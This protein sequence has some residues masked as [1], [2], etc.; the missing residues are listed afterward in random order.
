VALARA[1]ADVLAVEIDPA[2]AAALDE[3]ARGMSV[4]VIVADALRLDWESALRGREGWLMVS[5]LPYNVATPLILGMLERDLPIERYLVMVQREVGERLV[6]G[7]GD[8]GYS[9]SSVRVAYHAATRQHRRVPPDVFWPQPAV[10]SVLVELVPR[11][12]PPEDVDKDRLFRVVEEA[13]AQRRKTM[14]NALVRLGL[15]PGGAGGL[16]AGCGISAD[17][18]PEQLSLHDFACIARATL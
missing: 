11:A 9:G 4:R 10:E 16:L 13:F 15:E 7:P 14:R 17:A 6:A 8:E 1:G 3:V 5:N 18:R 2:L 12:T